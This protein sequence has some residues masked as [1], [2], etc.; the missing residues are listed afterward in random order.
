[1][2]QVRVVS[3]PVSGQVLRL[4]GCRMIRPAVLYP[5]WLRVNWPGMSLSETAVQRLPGRCRFQ[6]QVVPGVVRLVPVVSWIRS[7]PAC[8]LP[9]QCPCQRRHQPWRV[10]QPVWLV[11]YWVA[12]PVPGCSCS[13]RIR[14]RC[15]GTAMGSRLPM[16][17][18]V[19][20]VR[21]SQP[22]ACADGLAHRWFPRSVTEAMYG[23]AGIHYQGTGPGFPGSGSLAGAR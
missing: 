21:R 5:A 8:R 3:R 18:R 10:R 17:R 2:D 19:S 14:L 20:A 13:P 4:R 23:Q 7:L 12:R 11:P 16:L 22:A 9:D 1:M 15:P 6:G